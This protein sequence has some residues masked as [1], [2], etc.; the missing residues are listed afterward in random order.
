[1]IVITT[2]AEVELMLQLMAE[3]ESEARADDYKQ[4]HAKPVKLMTCTCCG[5]GYY[6]RQWWN[7]DEGFGIGDCC[8]KFANIHPELGENSCYGVPGIHFLIN[9]DEQQA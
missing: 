8:V 6:G 1:M 2:S 4:E 3:Q 5:N 9:G 7:Q